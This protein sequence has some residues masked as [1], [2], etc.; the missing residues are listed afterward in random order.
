MKM[1]YFQLYSNFYDSRWN[2][3]SFN[4]AQSKGK[5]YYASHIIALVLA[6]PNPRFIY[7]YIYCEFKIHLKETDDILR[8]YNTIDYEGGNK[9][10]E[11]KKV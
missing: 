5:K 8:Q 9:V 3:Y 1:L 10:E 11:L 2:I 6:Y 4:Y 7:M